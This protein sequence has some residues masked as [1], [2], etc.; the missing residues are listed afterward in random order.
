MFV[1]LGLQRGGDETVVG[2]DTHVASLVQLGFVAGSLHLG[3][4]VSMAKWKSPV[5]ATRSPHPSCGFTPAVRESSPPSL[6][7]LMAR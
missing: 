6:T 2:V 3:G 4:G 5:V 7:R 1:S